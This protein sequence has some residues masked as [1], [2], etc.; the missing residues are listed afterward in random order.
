MVGTFS[1]GGS[2]AAGH[3]VGVV[4]GVSVELTRPD[5]DA[6][7]R[8]VVLAGGLVTLTVA[9]RDALVAWVEALE[10]ALVWC[11]GSQDFQP[12]GKAREGWLKLCAPLLLPPPAPR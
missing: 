8:R 7:K 4:H 9:E 5:L 11:S 3:R 2:A 10:D 1:V 12:E 6:V